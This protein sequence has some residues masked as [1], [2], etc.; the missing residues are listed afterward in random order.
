MYK[1]IWVMNDRLL[2]SEAI[3]ATFALKKIFNVDSKTSFRKIRMCFFKKFLFYCL[4]IYL[5]VYT[6]FGPLPSIPAL[7]KAQDKAE[8]Q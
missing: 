3:F 7:I 5:H 1:L 6:L 4:Y 2:I 8:V